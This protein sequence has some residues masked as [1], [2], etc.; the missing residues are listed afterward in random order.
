MMT[1]ENL[2]SAMET[3]AN[4]DWDGAH[5]IVQVDES[6]EAAWIHGLLHRIE[7]DDANAGYWYRRAG[8]PFPTTDTDTERRDIAADL[9]LG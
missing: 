8:K 1:K 7:G 2:K 4:G 9:G 3:L 5:K 6:A